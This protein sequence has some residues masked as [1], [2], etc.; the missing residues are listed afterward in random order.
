VY[1]RFDGYAPRPEGTLSYTAG[2]KVTHFDR[3]E[4]LSPGD[5]ATSLMALSRGE[6]DWLDFVGIMAQTH[7]AV[8]DGLLTDR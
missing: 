4:W 2:P 1:E 3:V 5:S 7:H 6:V 8:D